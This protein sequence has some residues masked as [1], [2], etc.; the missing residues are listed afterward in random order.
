MA[1]ASFRY[2]CIPAE[3]EPLHTDVRRFLATAL[4]E[5]SAFCR[6]DSWMEADPA[7]SQKLGRCGWRGM[8]LPRQYEGHDASPWARYVVIEELLAAVASVS[9]HWIAD[10]QS[11]SIDFALWHGSPVSEIPARHLLA[12]HTED[13]LEAVSAI[14]DKRPAQFIGL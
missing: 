2:H 4:K 12:Q 14:L 8:T 7:F 3:V 11:R 13:H 9:A 6:A 5:R 10:P 1:L